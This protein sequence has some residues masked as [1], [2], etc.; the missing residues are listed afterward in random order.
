MIE[1][2]SYINP[3]NLCEFFNKYYSEFYQKHDLLQPMYVVISDF[4]GATYLKTKIAVKQGL[5]SGIKFSPLI[6]FLEERLK[7]DKKILS[8]QHLMLLLVNELVVKKGILDK[9]FEKIHEELDLSNKNKTISENAFKKLLN[10]LSK[11]SFLYDK[12]SLT[13]TDYF[14]DWKKN[15]LQFKEGKNKNLEKLYREIWQ[16]LFSDKYYLENQEGKKLELFGLVLEEAINDDYKNFFQNFPEELILI[17]FNI[18]P[19]PVLNILTCIYESNPENKLTILDFN[20][21]NQSWAEVP[22]TA[23]QESFIR[24]NEEKLSFTNWQSNDL[25]ACPLLKW[26]APLKDYYNIVENLIQDDYLP[27]DNDELMNPENNL[28]KLKYNIFIN[29]PVE[30]LNLDK[31]DDSVNFLSAKSAKEEVNFVIQS[32]LDKM[33]TNSALKFSDFLIAVHNNSENYFN[34]LAAAAE[35]FRVDLEILGGEDLYSKNQ[36]DF[37][38]L[39]FSVFKNNFQRESMIDFI[40]NSYLDCFASFE[41]RRKWVELIN[42]LD[43]FEGLNKEEDTFQYP[44]KDIYNWEQGLRRLLFGEAMEQSTGKVVVLGRKLNL[45]DG[46]GEQKFKYLP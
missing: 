17:D 37:I 27:L 35:E 31:V 8:Q 30:T 5:C 33:K 20:L 9:K 6:T 14:H 7:N 38:K 41:I 13:H 25:Q 36:H 1:F 16:L 18:L 22:F 42:N 29:S 45:K 23:K 43:I 32:I 3:E 28:E 46:K 4:S 19:Q 39:L 44:E 21:L 12:F 2:K 34:L 11:M 40:M 24:K 26:G 10:L 15:N